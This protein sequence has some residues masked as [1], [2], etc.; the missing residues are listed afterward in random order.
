MVW[1][2]REVEGTQKVIVRFLDEAGNA[3]DQVVEVNVDM[4]VP[5]WLSYASHSAV[6]E[7]G[8]SGLDA[9]SATWSVS[10]DGG[11]TWGDWQ[12]L[13]LTVSSGI[14]DPVQL[15][16][17]SDPGGHLRFRI[18]DVAGNVSESAP[19]APMPSVTPSV[20]SSPTAT[21]EPT[22]PPETVAPTRPVLETC[23]VPLILK[24]A[25]E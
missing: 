20:T 2:V 4:S 25:G 11:D 16:A 18:Q 1:D 6:V 3:Y 14:T 12:R 19:L 10:H 24:R 15:T 5:Q 22:L 23:A 9:D 7:D 21:Q 13:S 8:V 17:P